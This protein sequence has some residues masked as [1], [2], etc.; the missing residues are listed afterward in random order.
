MSPSS[1][2]PATQIETYVLVGSRAWGVDVSADGKRLYVANGLSDDITIVD[3]AARKALKSVPV[4]RVPHT[5]V[6]DE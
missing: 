1:T 6:V 2:Q 5:I 4:G 3:I